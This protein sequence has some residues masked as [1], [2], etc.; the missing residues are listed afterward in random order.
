MSIHTHIALDLTL[1]HSLMCL[2]LKAA[3]VEMCNAPP[4]I[5]TISGEWAH[6]D[7]TAI[8]S[9]PFAIIP[10]GHVSIS[11]T[12]VPVAIGNSRSHFRSKS[13]E[14]AYNRTNH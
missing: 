2:A 9:S 13:V 11:W 14:D 1:P 3:V 4:S 8:V 12:T 10:C 7:S 6:F 5:T